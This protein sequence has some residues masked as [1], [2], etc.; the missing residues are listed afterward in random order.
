MMEV[1]VPFALVFLS[2][3]PH[4]RLMKE[5]FS[6]FQPTFSSMGQCQYFLKGSRMWVFV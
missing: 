1:F 3:D 6:V 4:N 5:V 2:P